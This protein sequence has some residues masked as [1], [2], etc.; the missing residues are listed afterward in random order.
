[1]KTDGLMGKSC[2]FYYITDRYAELLRIERI[3]GKF[4]MGN[5]NQFDLRDK[6]PDW[7]DWKARWSLPSG[8]SS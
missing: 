2:Q 7:S 3:E 8:F 4:G 5:G 6:P 1:M